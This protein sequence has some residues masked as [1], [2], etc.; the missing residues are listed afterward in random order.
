MFNATFSGGENFQASFSAPEIVAADFG[1]TTIKSEVE[2]YEGP[3]DFTPGEDAQ[4]IQIS[5]KTGTRDITVQAI[6]QNY[7]RLT[8]DGSVLRVW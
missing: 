4:V 2:P 6:P 1:E 8:Y 3:Y 5:G 7:G